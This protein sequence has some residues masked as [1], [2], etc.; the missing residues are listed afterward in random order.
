MF[1]KVLAG[2]FSKSIGPYRRYCSRQSSP[3]RCTDLSSLLFTVT[4]DLM[5]ID[6]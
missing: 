3:C 5:D 4:L 6:V 2:I 1:A